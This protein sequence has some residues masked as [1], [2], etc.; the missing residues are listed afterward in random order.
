MTRVALHVGACCPGRFGDL[1]AS[2]QELISTAEKGDSDETGRQMVAQANKL[3]GL[4]LK[5]AQQM[6]NREEIVWDDVIR[7]HFRKLQA[8]CDKRPEKNVEA[9]MHQMVILPDFN[10]ITQE[11]LSKMRLDAVVKAGTVG[12][13]SKIVN[14]SGDF[15]ALKTINPQS[16]ELYKADFAMFE[17]PFVFLVTKLIEASSLA[18]DGDFMNRLI[19]MVHNLNN[20]I[21]NE[22][23]KRNVMN[24]FDLKIEANNL[25]AARQYYEREL[26]DFKFRTPRVVAVA[27]DGSALVM[28]W[29]DG[30]TL[31]DAVQHPAQRV[32]LSAE[33]LCPALLQRF[34]VDIFVRNRLHGDLHPGNII[35]NQT[36][37]WVFD[38]G[39]EIV[40]DNRQLSVIYRLLRHIHCVEDRDNDLCKEAFEQLGVS[41][42]AEHKGPRQYFFLS[43][44]FDL[45]EGMVGLN[46][47]ENFNGTSCLSIPPWVYLMQK[48]F[49]SFVV[50]LQKIRSLPDGARVD[51]G[52]MIAD[53]FDNIPEPDGV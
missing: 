20:S 4:P 29:I 18:V 43:K 33:V 19:A 32:A 36:S 16:K 14:S 53:I 7:G 45:I 48:A 31:S 37:L 24:E 26:G 12:E 34:F 42:T 39:S 50:T 13:V 22:E 35:P 1:S 6:G 47:D 44:S 52:S 41:T 17:G 2:L 30:L 23:F 3:K 38:L 25:N 8:D 10:E 11:A 40:F 9:Q 5:V 46:F 27:Q 49:A 21:A 28:E 15:F 51:M